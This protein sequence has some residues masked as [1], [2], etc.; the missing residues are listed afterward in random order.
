MT[1][2]RADVVREVRS[3]IGTPYHLAA[4]VKSVGVDCAM[5]VLRVYA[6]LGLIAPFDPRPYSSD[7]MLHRSE[8]IYLKLVRERAREI[9]REDALPGDL[10]MFKVGRCYAHAGIIVEINPLTMV[11]AY[12]NA[13]M[14]VE[15]IVGRNAEIVEKL[16][17]AI[18]ASYWGR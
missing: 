10:V 14:V 16:G 18:F 2:S 6:D 11:H 17:T 13:R 12:K 1:Q 3:W 15:E 7:W 9:P 5:L 8:E 4:D